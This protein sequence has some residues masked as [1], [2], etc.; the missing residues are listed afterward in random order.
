FEAN[1]ASGTDAGG[2]AAEPIDWAVLFP[3]GALNGVAAGDKLSVSGAATLNVLDGLVVLKVREFDMQL[4]RVSGSDGIGGTTLT[5][6]WAMTVTLNDVTL[7]VGPGGSLDD[8]G[9]ALD[10]TD[11]T[12]FSDDTVQAGDLGFSG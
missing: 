11:P 4:G 7:G 12:T 9:T 8:G 1:F 10:V 6:A 5:D 3:G 2:G